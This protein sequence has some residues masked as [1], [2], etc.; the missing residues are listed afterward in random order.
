MLAEHGLDR[1]FG[2]QVYSDEVGIRKPNP[3]IIELA[4]TALGVTADRCWYVGDTLDRD[5]VAGRRAEVAA[6]VVTRSHHTDAPPFGVA[7]EPDAVFDTPEGLADALEAAGPARSPVRT[8]IPAAKP[9][10]A[11]LLIDHGGVISHSQPDPD[12]MGEFAAEVARRLTGA[13]EQVAPAQALELIEKGRERHHLRKQQ[14]HRAHVETGAPLAEVQPV[15]FWRDLVGAELPERQR[16]ILTAEAFDLMH[17]LGR[18][19]SRRIL[20]T[21][22]RELLETCRDAGLAVVVVSNTINGRAVRAQC[23]EHD[24]DGL[25][26]AY[27]CSD[28]AGVR[29][30]DPTIVREALRVA[31]ADPARTWFY[32]D[33]PENDAEAARACGITHRVIVRGGSTPDETVDRALTSGLVTTAVPDAGQLA[34]LIAAEHRTDADA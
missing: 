20:R 3:R 22:V 24:L 12:A 14:R 1:A 25:I 15:D 33:K 30:P 31:A 27:V 19:K 2:V 17:L 23:A 7:A 9:A 18:A 11:A 5:V 34:A 8:S 16:A 6:V 29:K 13:G 10:R 32:G 4:A 21:G 26:G 28:E